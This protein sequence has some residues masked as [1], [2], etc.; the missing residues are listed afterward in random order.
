MKNHLGAFPKLG[1]QLIIL[2][3]GILVPGGV[4]HSATMVSTRLFDGMSGFCIIEDLPPV[5]A[6]GPEDRVGFAPIATSC[7]L[8]RKLGVNSAASEG[9]HLN[10][11]LQVAIEQFHAS[12]E[13]LEKISVTVNELAAEPKPTSSE[14][15]TQRRH[16]VAEIREALLGFTR[17]PRLQR[18]SAGIQAESLR[19]QAKLMIIQE[20]LGI[21]IKKDEAFGLLAQSYVLDPNNP[22]THYDLGS[23]LLG[24]EKSC[25]GKIYG[26]FDSCRKFII[27]ALRGAVDRAGLEELSLKWFSDGY[28][29]FASGILQ[30]LIGSYRSSFAGREL[31]TQCERVTRM[32]TQM[33]L[34]LLLEHFEKRR[35][36]IIG[37]LEAEILQQLRSHHYSESGLE[38]LAPATRL[39]SQNAWIKE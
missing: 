17:N 6:F 12:T 35:S 11:D 19:L 15:R 2:L 4:V 29:G 3:I 22:T 21:D 33:T 28:N 13:V 37:N 36:K 26:L 20:K 5:G 7:E 25:N 18:F 27:G 9:V 1:Q 31:M 32:K 16:T 8:I 34:K 24:I 10:T 30:V 38:F 39:E 23:T 14:I